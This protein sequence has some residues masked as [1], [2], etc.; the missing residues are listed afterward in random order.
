MRYKIALLTAAATQALR[1][2]DPGRIAQSVR[3]GEGDRVGAPYDA[4]DR[5]RHATHSKVTARRA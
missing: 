1:G 2:A 3:R 4:G 5:S